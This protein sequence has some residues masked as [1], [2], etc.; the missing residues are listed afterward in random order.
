MLMR[1]GESTGNREQRISG[2]K[3]DDLTTVGEQ[4]VQQLA[5]VL[6]QTSWSPTHLYS[7]PL[8]RATRT[9][10]ILRHSCSSP[11]SPLPIQTLD[12]L[13]EID[14]GVLQGLTWVEAQHR[15]RKLC[16]ALEASSTWIPIPEAESLQA[17]RDRAHQ[18]IQHL[19]QQHQNS[20]RIWVVSHGGILQF[21][22]AELLEMPRVW[23][24]AIPP[25]A[26]FEFELALEHWTTTDQNRHNPTLWK[27]CR[28]N[29]TLHLHPA[30]SASHL[31][32][33]Y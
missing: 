13:R 10:D 22:I 5:Q 12:C 19:L 30:S 11:A 21:L 24:L 7:S 15:Y 29:Q 14:H 33:L 32:C 27:V 18:F 17:C 16:A 2:H 1:H 3:D 4:Q 26:L 31:S 9:A 25:T 6:N 8:L 20:D 23:G 28:F